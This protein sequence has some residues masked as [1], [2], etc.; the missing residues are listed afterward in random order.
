MRGLAA[1]FGISTRHAFYSQML[2]ELE[3]SMKTCTKCK[4]TKPFSDFHNCASKTDGKMSACKECRNSYN[5]K[6]LKEIGYDV[7]YQRALQSIGEDNYKAKARA[8]YEKNKEKVK[9]RSRQW[10]KDNAEQ[11]K[12]TNREDYLKNRER[13]VANAKKWSEENRERR[14]EIGLRYYRKKREEMS[15]EFIASVAA[16]KMIRRVLDITGKR[17][18]RKTTDILG[19]TKQ[20][21]EAHIS[22]QFKDGMS[23]KN[24]GEWHI[25]HIIPVSELVKCGVTDPAKINALSN[26][27][28]LWAKENLEKRDGFVLA[29]PCTAHITRISKCRQI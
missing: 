20:D 17:K 19:Y 24:Y 22:A 25:D 15:P 13:Y 14:L 21:L 6:K 27:Q 1:S 10:S 9:A 23:W 18:A 8:Y 3:A 26:L 5:R 12:E 29:P 2:A 7:L 4:V 16:R 11:K 28:P